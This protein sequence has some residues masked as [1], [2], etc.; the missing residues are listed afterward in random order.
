MKLKRKIFAS[1]LSLSMLAG[2]LSGICYADNENGIS[3]TEDPDEKQI[4]IANI[5]GAV[6]GYSYITEA[7][8]TDS[9]KIIC[10]GQ[11]NS[12]N[13]I[14]EIDTNGKLIAEKS[15][16]EITDYT[17]KSCGDKICLLYREYSAPDID[18]DSIDD[19]NIN[20]ITAAFLSASKD[21]YSAVYGEEL[22]LISKT[23]ISS[24]FGVSN[25]QYCDADDERICYVTDR[26][27]LYISDT[28]GGNNRLVSDISENG[29]SGYFISGMAIADKYAALTISDGYSVI[30]AAVDIE[31]GE[32]FTKKA[33]Q[34]FSCIKVSGNI[35]SWNYSDG[36]SAETVIFSD[37]KFSSRR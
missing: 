20:E 24:L 11:K 13:Y 9:G 37:G 23:N 6:E 35:I 25:N 30:Y 17:L 22:N 27:K 18:L 28:D 8:I 4:D 10:I 33:P 21:L 32:I 26:T 12:C 36:N 5:S 19:E 7:V 2:C 15:L 34:G 31:T 14:F 16:G 1:A 29:Y 3:I